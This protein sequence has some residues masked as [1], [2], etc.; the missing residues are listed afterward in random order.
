MIDSKIYRNRNEDEYNAI[1]HKQSD[2]ILWMRERLSY[3]YMVINEFIPN[4]DWRNA[5]E[6]IQQWNEYYYHLEYEIERN[7][8]KAQRLFLQENEKYLIFRDVSLR[9][10]DPCIEMHRQSIKKL[11]VISQNIAAEDSIL[12]NNELR[13]R[14]FKGENSLNIAIAHIKHRFNTVQKV[15]DRIQEKLEDNT[16]TE[17]LNLNELLEESIFKEIQKFLIKQGILN[18]HGK[19]RRGARKIFLPSYLKQL[20]LDLDFN[21]KGA[22]ILD[23]CKYTFA[24]DGSISSIKQ[25]TSADSQEFRKLY[26]NHV[27]D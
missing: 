23:I 19:C 6:F 4:K 20:S 2:F 12:I 8:G 27:N 22:E 16:S 5:S 11:E 24:Y 17:K 18:Q 14:G 15:L 25:A 9:E 3:N 26:I 7:F 1:L 10:F 13:P 21:W